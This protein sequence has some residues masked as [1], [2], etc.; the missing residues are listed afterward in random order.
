MGAEY[1]GVPIAASGSCELCWKSCSLLVPVVNYP[2]TVIGQTLE[3]G[4]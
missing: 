1:V 2:R 4:Q 3:R